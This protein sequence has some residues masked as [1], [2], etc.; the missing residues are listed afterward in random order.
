MKR[1]LYFDP[2]GV[3]VQKLGIPVVSSLHNAAEHAELESLEPFASGR[4]RIR[5]CKVG[6][7]RNQ[8]R[9]FYMIYTKYRRTDTNYAIIEESGN[10]ESW[11]GP[12]V[13]MRLDTASA[14]RLVSITSKT[15][16][17]MAIQA[18][19]RYVFYTIVPYSCSPVGKVHKDHERQYFHPAAQNGPMAPEAAGGG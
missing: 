4:E 14:T 18:V 15:H 11:N 13:V 17:D 2:D 1:S 10:Q 3:G 16:K 5:G 9:H 12:L 6:I 7:R 8:R 19:A